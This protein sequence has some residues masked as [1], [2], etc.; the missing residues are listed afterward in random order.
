MTS[1]H[2]STV[3]SVVRHKQK[4]Q[5][6]RSLTVTRGVSGSTSGSN[7]GLGP[8]G[9]GCGGG[10][11][12]GGGAGSGGGSKGTGGRD[13][14]CSTF[15]L[16]NANV[17]HYPARALNSDAGDR[18][19]IALAPA[20]AATEPESE[21]QPPPA[22]QQHHYQPQQQSRKSEPSLQSD[23]YV[24]K[25]IKP[26]ILIVG[27]QEGATGPGPVDPYAM[28][29]SASY[30]YS[31]SNATQYTDSN[32]YS[33]GDAMHNSWTC[34]TSNTPPHGT[35]SDGPLHFSFA[36]PPQCTPYTA[37]G[38][39]NCSSNAT[40]AAA[41]DSTGI[42][43]GAFSVLS[44]LT[45]SATS[46][47][48]QSSIDL[49]TPSSLDPRPPIA[50]CS[51]FSLRSGAEGQAPALKRQLPGER[52]QAHQQRQRANAYSYQSKDT[53]VDYT[54]TDMDCTRTRTPNSALVDQQDPSTRLSAILNKTF[55]DQSPLECAGHSPSSGACALE[56]EFGDVMPLGQRPMSFYSGRVANKLIPGR[57][58]SES[59]D[60][61][62]NSR[63]YQQPHSLLRFAPGG[64][65]EVVSEVA[66]CEWADLQRRTEAA[67]G[68]ASE[69]TA[70]LRRSKMLDRSARQSTISLTDE[71]L[72]H[73][74][75]HHQPHVG[76]PELFAPASTP[77]ASLTA[78]KHN[79]SV[80]LPVSSTPTSK[81]AADPPPPYPQPQPQPTATAQP[82]SFAQRMSFREQI[83]SIFQSTML[84]H[85]RPASRRRLQRLR[86]LP[87]DSSLSV[88]PT[89]PGK[90]APWGGPLEPGA[91][92]GTETVDGKAADADILE[93]EIDPRKFCLLI[94]PNSAFR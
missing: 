83:T 72:T 86:H 87:Q 23:R 13:H 65:N 75:F 58:K 55:T 85:N 77:I 49:L 69:A 25:F 3:A 22:Q 52:V 12:G 32:K 93:E 1:L 63:Y 28:T 29:N 73:L 19:L 94:H 90:S 59:L 37:A 11:G 45:P 7:S 89:G 78:G 66:E 79:C 54:D 34:S 46:L 5:Q 61:R 44:P 76:S 70:L 47:R 42:A 84:E 91:S 4:Q 39:P 67:G 57:R 80:E 6:H 9:G 82:S 50:S 38:A 48:L 26:S 64:A 36:L 81:S 24:N 17:R 35:T 43:S 53:E 62:A 74:H 33:S 51:S 20:R 16:H 41:I 71:P 15:S 88:S 8:G 14:R 27:C 31:T 21:T 92:A 18:T 60:A 40:L 10:A 56:A 68:V 2:G 30:G